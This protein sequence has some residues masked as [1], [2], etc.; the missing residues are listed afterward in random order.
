MR[1]WERAKGDRVFKGVCGGLAALV[2]MP[3]NLIR[4]LWIVLAVFADLGVPLLVLYI[5]LIFVLPN[6]D[7]SPRENFS[8]DLRQTHQRG[9]GIAIAMGLIAIGVLLLVR[10]IWSMDLGAYLRPVLWMGKGILLI[11]FA[12]RSLE[13]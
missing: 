3:S 9:W 1:R 12:A 13:T 8:L 2:R 11:L 10:S 5:I 4:A 6:E 7:G